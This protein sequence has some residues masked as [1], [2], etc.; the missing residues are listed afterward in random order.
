MIFKLTQLLISLSIKSRNNNLLFTPYTGVSV[1]FILLFVYLVT[2]YLN[3]AHCFMLIS[4][5]F[6]V[7]FEVQE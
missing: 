1:D 4:L 6:E 7:P 2:V 5:A 3:I